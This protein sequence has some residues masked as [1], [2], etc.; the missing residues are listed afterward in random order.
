MHKETLSQETKLKNKQTNKNTR[1]GMCAHEY[2]ACRGQRGHEI[3][4]EL[5]LH[6]I[7]CLM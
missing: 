6:V 1:D 4:L 2:N 7:L 5:E 3:F